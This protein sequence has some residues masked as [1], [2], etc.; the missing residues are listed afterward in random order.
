[1]AAARPVLASSGSRLER[2]GQLGFGHGAWATATA[3]TT[4]DGY[5][6]LF[7]VLLEP[8]AVDKRRTGT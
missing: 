4:I 1:M 3:G 6:S 8:A 2:Y 7:F 5:R